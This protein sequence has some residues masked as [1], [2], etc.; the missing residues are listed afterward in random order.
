MIIRQDIILLPRRRFTVAPEIVRRLAEQARK[1]T[2][3]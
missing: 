3:G 2:I 1:K